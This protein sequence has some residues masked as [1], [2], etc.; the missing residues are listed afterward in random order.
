MEDQNRP[1]TGERIITQNSAV[2]LRPWEQEDAP[3]LA[4]YAN[5]PR[6]AAS[7]RDVF[8]SPY[9]LDDA[10]RFIALATGSSS[11]ASA[12]MAPGMLRAIEVNRKFV[13]GISIS[14][15][16]DVYRKT[17]EIGY[18]LAEPFWGRGIVTDA[19]LALV[20]VAFERFD[21]VRLQAG[22]F[23]NNPASMRVLGKCG[24]TREA[25]LKNAIT[26]NG[27]VMDEV[28]H[29]RFRDE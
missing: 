8:P 24:F 14:L 28:M 29:A 25:V 10:N 3:T 27:I 20:P 13:G 22:V 1:V 26:K 2:V 6:I 11:G 16:D 21:I 23:A 19:V 18:W 9:T 17:A 7:L 4:E 12:D 15:L 5:N